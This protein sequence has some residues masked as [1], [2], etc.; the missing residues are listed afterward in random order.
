MIYPGG[1]LVT[2]YLQAHNWP[3]I[4]FLRAAELPHGVAGLHAVVV[5]EI[6]NEQV[7][8][9]DPSLDHQL[10]LDSSMFLRAWTGFGNQ[11]LVVWI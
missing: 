7:T 3:V 2:F 8:C 11:G 9:L 6:Q 4:A 1:T 10:L 5:V